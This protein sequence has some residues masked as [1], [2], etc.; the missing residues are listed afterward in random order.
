MEQTQTTGL[1]SD[2]IAGAHRFAHHAMAT[3]FEILVAGSDP[4]YAA[5]AARAAF[6]KLDLIEKEISRY[7]P[8]SDISRINSLS[9]GES[10]LLGPDAFRCLSLSARLHADT[11]GAFDVTIGSLLQ[12][13]RKKGRGSS[14][15]REEL[16]LARRRTGM[17]LLRLD[18]SKHR[19]E[20]PTRPVQ[21]DLGGIGKGY[22][23]DRMAELLREWDIRSAL[24]HGGWSSALAL[25]AP[26]G[27]RGWPVRFEGPGKGMKSLV[28]FHLENRAVSGS[29]FTK[30]R[31]I[32]DPRSGRPARGRL[33]SWACAPTAATADALSTA[34]LVMSLAEIEDYLKSHTD[35]LA[36]FLKED[37][38]AVVRKGRGIP[39]GLPGPINQ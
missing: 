13:W 34:I 2:P 11:G 19:V 39:A 27:R 4:L 29:G 17:H 36:V 23:V 12:C 8:G 18:A 33:A 26:P 30:G 15:S 25:D 16:E 5:Q 20:V 31:N 32:I 28:R 3:T 21:I 7:I 22:G 10:L 35:S 1:G 9:A 37:G 6:E 24:I 14:P 38:K